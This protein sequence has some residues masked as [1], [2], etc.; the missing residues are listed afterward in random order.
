MSKSKIVMLLLLQNKVYKV[1]I[2]WEFEE[3]KVKKLDTESCGL[4]ACKQHCSKL[5]SF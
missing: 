2:I 5:I 4:W 3:I 1:K